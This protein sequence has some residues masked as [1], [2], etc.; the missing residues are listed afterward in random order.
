[1]LAAMSQEAAAL[2]QKLDGQCEEYLGL[3]HEYTAARER[4]AK[5]SS[6]GYFSLAQANFATP[7]RTRFGQDQYDERMQAT[8]AVQVEPSQHDAASFVL[9]SPYK[10]NVEPS[11]GRLTGDSAGGDR[12]SEDQEGGSEPRTSLVQVQDPIRW[13]GI[14]VPQALKSCQAAFID[15]VACTAATASLDS[16]MKALEVEIRR[17]KKRLSKY[18]QP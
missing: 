8:R 3:L 7:N 5:L 12:E 18:Q 1:M 4:L 15:V 13:F 10:L 9:T 14:L 17:T 16:T 11:M 6:D 2:E